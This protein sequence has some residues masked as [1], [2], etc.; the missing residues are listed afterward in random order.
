VSDT[1]AH[2]VVDGLRRLLPADL[3]RVGA[4]IEPRYF[5]D[6]VV[7]SGQEDAPVALT[8]PRTTADVAAILRVCHAHGAPVVPQGGLTGLTG[9]GAPVAGAVLVSLERMRAVEEL[10]PVASTITVQAGATLQAVQEAADAADLLYPLD[11]GGR[12][13]CAIGGNI[14][15]NAGGNRVLRYGMTRDLVLGLEV[16]L[17]DGTVVT[18]LNKMLKNNAAYD[19]KHLFIGAE[20]TLGIVTR[21]VLRL[22][23]KP[24]G[25]DTA[26]CAFRDFDAVYAFLR[27]ARAK[28]AGSLSAFE[29]MWPSFYAHAAAGRSAPP[30]PAGYA[31]YVLIE[32]MGTDPERDAAHFAGFIESA[33]ED[34][35]VADAVLAKSIA[36]TRAL[37][38]IRDMSGELVRTLQP[39]A[40][41]DVSIETGQ[42]DAFERAC[43]ARLRETWP[44]AETICFGHLADSNL[45]MFVTVDERPFPEHA[46]EDVVY[47]SVRD[48]G[49]SISA[50][51]GIGVIK[52]PYLAYSRTPEELALMK[53]VKAA[54]DPRGILNPGKVFQ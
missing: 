31:A 5:G 44:S 7:R 23:P 43:R 3:V 8:L 48:W 45:H 27:R 9:G 50:E 17:A 21:A 51:H 19:L 11:I 28:L 41:F 52:K 6:W 18:S 46:I 53:V 12:G 54:L 38:A 32:A 35:L 1:L 20:G 22:F 24:L 37:W 40:N 14:S 25:T 47:A 16:V 2:T 10:D 26:L 15:T 39:L 13:S 33:V 42:I 49:G 34:E 4:D 30:I 36:E 29:L